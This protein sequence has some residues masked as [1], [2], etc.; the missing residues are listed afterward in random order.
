MIETL[1]SIGAV[2]AAGWWIITPLVL[3]YLFQEV[4]LFAARKKFTESISWITLDVRVPRDILKSPKSMEQIFAAVH[5]TYSFGITFKNKWLKGEVEKWMSFEIIGFSGGVHLYIRLPQEFRNLIEAAVYSQYP[6]AEII[7]IEDYLNVLPN[8]LPNATYDCFGYEF[9]FTKDNPYP[10]RTY[11]EFEDPQEEKRLDSLAS[12]FEVMAGLKEGEVILFQIM[13]RP[14]NDSWKKEGEELIDVI[15]GKKKQGKQSFFGALLEGIIEFIKN[16]TKAPVEYPIWGEPKLAEKQEPLKADQLT[17]VHKEAI[18][19]IARKISKV[20]FEVNMRF[21]YIDH[22]SAFT[23][24]NVAAFSG[25]IRQL[26]SQTLNGLRVNIKTMTKVKWL[27]KKRR[28]TMRK[29]KLFRNY[30]IVRMNNK[31]IMI[32]N[33]EELATLFHFPTQFVEAPTLR[34]TESRRGEAPPGLPIEE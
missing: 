2:F 16:L 15:R 31:N 19:A 30:R 33:T 34:R 9:S 27:F 22:R 11:F 14:T 4:W 29:K 24:S 32:L 13:T 21:I 23:S 25:A 17:P 26:S 3:F 5:G 20:G 10:I 6:D 8:A 7:Q 1:Q 12:V 18:D 28:V